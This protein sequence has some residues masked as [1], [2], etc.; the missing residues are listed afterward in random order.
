MP[1]NI[2]P[3]KA[4]ENFIKLEPVTK[5]VPLPRGIR[6]PKAHN[7]MHAIFHVYKVVV[8]RGRFYALA[9]G[10]E[11][12][13]W[14]RCFYVYLYERE[15]VG[16]AG[17]VT[18]PHCRIAHDRLNARPAEFYFGRGTPSYVPDLVFHNGRLFVTNHGEE[19]EPFELEALPSA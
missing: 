8:H 17:E 5:P 18:P 3:A 15:S 9:E 12:H 2:A 7:P 11:S 4:P 10:W 1:L 13:T 19:G 16:E 6:A 14:G